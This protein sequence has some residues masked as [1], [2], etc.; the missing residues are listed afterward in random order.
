LI[1][2][3]GECGGNVFIALVEGGED[4]VVEGVKVKVWSLVREFLLSSLKMRAIAI[5]RQGLRHE[6]LWWCFY[7]L[8]TARAA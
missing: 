8:D 3:G 4:G 6:L 7:I 1:V 5:L 2:L